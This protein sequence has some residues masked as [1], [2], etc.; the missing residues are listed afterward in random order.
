M[1]PL[2]RH[3][4]AWLALLTAAWPAAAQ[5]PVDMLL[6]CGI[7]MVRPMTEIARAFE[8]RENVRITI[9][10]GGSEDLYQS[11]KKSGVGDWYLPGEPSYRDKHL[12]E[13][14]LGEYAVVGYNQMALV[15]QK[16][17]PKKVKPDPRELLRKDLVVILGN[18]ESGSVGQEAKAIL[19]RLGIYPQVVRASAFLVPDSRSLMLAMRKGEAD[20]TMS[21]RATGLV[22]DNAEKLDV[23]DLPT[24]LARPQPLLLNLLKSTRQP[25]LARR[26][27]AFAAGEE[28]QAIFR[29]HGFLDNK[30][31]ANR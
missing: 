13:G 18:A 9:S 2:R 4:L 28:G 30:A 20:L 16:G 7:T 15:V 31:L 19:D 8:K 26:F 5:Q 11:A 6:Y 23:I 17:N 25:E 24:T 10:Q 29:K 3:L 14:L 27:M 12:A 22:P 1:R 21:W